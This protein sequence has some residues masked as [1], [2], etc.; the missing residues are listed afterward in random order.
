MKLSKWLCIMGLLLLTAACE[1]EDF[2]KNLKSMQFNSSIE[3]LTSSDNSKVFLYKEQWVFWELGDQIS[4]GSDLSTGTP[5]VGDLVNASP[6][7]DFENFNG[8]FIAPLPEGSKYFVGLHPQRAALL[9]RNELAAEERAGGAG[10]GMLDR[11]SGVEG[12]MV[13]EG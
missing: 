8:V 13:D 6:G 5:Q 11:G 2:P 7:T 12:A 1:K 10:G 3:A 4:I 9:P